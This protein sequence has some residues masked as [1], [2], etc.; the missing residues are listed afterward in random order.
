[1]TLRAMRLS[2]R[3]CVRRLLK[4]SDF[5]LTIPRPFASVGRLNVCSIFQTPSL[6][7]FPAWQS[8]MYISD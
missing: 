7:G 4:A 6:F 3:V 5:C 8:M 2:W 1:M